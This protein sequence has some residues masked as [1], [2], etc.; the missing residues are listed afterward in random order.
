MSPPLRIAVLHYHLRRGG[1]SRV[2]Q[3]ARDAL[4]RKR[5]QMAVVVGEAPGQQGAPGI[6]VVKG[7]QYGA[8]TAQIEA[9]ISDLRSAAT[10]VLGG[11]PDI[12]H[13]HNHSLGK[14]LTLPRIVGKL[15][16]AGER[17]LLQ[18]HD[19]AEDSRPANYRYLRQGL[20]QDA[21]GKL[22]PC[23]Q[24]VRY[25][26]LTGRDRDLLAKAGAPIQCLQILPNPVPPPIVANGNECDNFPENLIVYPSRAIRRKNLGELLLWALLDPE[27]H[28]YGVTL[29][30]LNPKE[31]ELYRHWVGLARELGLPIEFELGSRYPFAAI[32]SSASAAITCSLGEGYGMAFVEPWMS[33][34]PLIG[35]KLPEITSGFEQLG[36][37]LSHCYQRLDIP[38]K[39]LGRE[40][41]VARLQAARTAMLEHYGRRPGQSDLE[42]V[43]A[44]TVVD[45]GIDF[46]ALDEE[47][48]SDT[49]RRLADSTRLRKGIGQELPIA[50]AR[51][52]IDSNRAAI[53]QGLS[54]ERY[55]L[56]LE[57]I[58]SGL[59]DAPCEQCEYLNPAVLLDQFLD[60]GRFR[61][62]LA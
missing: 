19:F 39:L 48:Q 5:F 24:R 32:L 21:F 51:A 50:A 23:S 47:L 16:A 18:P 54:L 28:R 52:R 35:R 34:C 8:D 53:E 40:R 61:A 1:V 46:A 44:S 43:L 27:K 3:H 22:Y 2:I 6:A 56:M 26:L 36:I 62:L 9:L 12:W 17:M 10:K 13:I 29:A 11:P 14:N 38:V 30:P 33:G 37:D 60:P 25:A 31:Q 55:R 4:D 42:E 57:Q 41:I 59:M 49:L 45:G 7:L 20:P 15:A 58:Y